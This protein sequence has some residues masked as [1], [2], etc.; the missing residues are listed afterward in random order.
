MTSALFSVLN[1]RSVALRNRVVITPMCQYSAQDG[2]VNDWHMVQYGRFAVG[3]AGMVVVE[4]TAVLPEGRI[5]PGDL[6]VWSDDHIA[7]LARIANFLRDQGTVSCLQLNHAGR[8]AATQRPWHGAGPLSEIDLT[9]RRDAAWQVVAPSA[10]P[11]GA[12]WP[13][14]HELTHK[15][16][17]AIQE[18]F[19]D[20]ARRA[21]AAGFDAIELHCAHGYLLHQF[22]SALSNRRADE[23]GGDLAGRMRLPLQIAREL[24]ALWPDDKPVLVR[25]SAVD[26][27]E[28]GIEV[29]DTI[30]FARE[31]KEIGIDVVDCS[32]GGLQGA[33]TAARLPR[34][35]G[36]QVEFAEAVRKGAGI[37]TMA[38][39]L[40]LTPE[41][42]NSI[43][44][45]GRADLVA[46]GRAALDDPNWPLHAA[47]ALEGEDFSLWPPQ[48]RWWLERR[49]AILK[50]M[51]G[52]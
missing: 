50:A 6:G 33:A 4:A 20:G 30:A 43:V 17:E 5:S 47:K 16:I 14:P 37:G 8:K 31:L 35:E 15:E 45:Q 40:I 21:L 22:L 51:Q 29:A 12:G 38:V 10:L 34:G 3:G 13:V 24:R 32:T 28:G 39:G 48:H 26:N 49:A 52:E 1:L 42:A 41:L 46:I 23:F 9:E 18:A 27:I 11:V 19:V 36:F 25:V 44:A 7:G 2:F